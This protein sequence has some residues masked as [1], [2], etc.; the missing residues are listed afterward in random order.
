VASWEKFTKENPDTA[1][2]VSRLELGLHRHSIYAVTHVQNARLQCLEENTS[3]DSNPYYYRHM[4]IHKGPGEVKK[5]H[6][7]EEWIEMVEVHDEIRH[8]AVMRMRMTPFSRSIVDYDEKTHCKPQTSERTSCWNTVN[9]VG[10]KLVSSLPA[11]VGIP[12]SF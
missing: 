5:L 12:F 2:L 7:V 9:V 1:L 3:T 4:P 11:T 10:T 8:V 6:R